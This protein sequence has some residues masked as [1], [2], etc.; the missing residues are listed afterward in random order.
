ML[1]VL[2]AQGYHFLVLLAKVRSLRAFPRG[3]GDDEQVE[4]AN[5]FRLVL[6]LNS[7]ELRPLDLLRLPK[8][9]TVVNGD[10]HVGRGE[11]VV[12]ENV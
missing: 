2:F 6:V 1:V 10:D 9:K 7:V 4:N 12:F 5:E 11:L 8:T 3:D